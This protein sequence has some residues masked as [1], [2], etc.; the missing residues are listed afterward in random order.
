[1]LHVRQNSLSAI[2]SGLATILPT[3]GLVLCAQ[4]KGINHAFV[5]FRIAKCRAR[6]ALRGWSGAFIILSVTHVRSL[7][8][9][10]LTDG[11]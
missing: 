2:K 7:V 8:R 1:M 10:G 6:R 4:L 5:L 11:P 3:A 9:D